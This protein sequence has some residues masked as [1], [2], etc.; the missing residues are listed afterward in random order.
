[1]LQFAGQEAV[2]GAKKAREENI[3]KTEA[4][5][6]ENYSNLIFQIVSEI[7]F[8]IPDNVNENDPLL[9]KYQPSLKYRG[10]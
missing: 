6:I 9:R 2:T 4:S 8:L 1:M 10:N 7:G 5:K 3:L